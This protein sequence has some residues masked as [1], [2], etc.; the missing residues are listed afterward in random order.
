MKEYSVVCIGENIRIYYVYIAD[1]LDTEQY[2]GDI[3]CVLDHIGDMPS[4][5]V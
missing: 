2:V 3:V 5:R 4:Y 1:I